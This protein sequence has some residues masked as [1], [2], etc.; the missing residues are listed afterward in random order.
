M[1]QIAAKNRQI[2]LTGRVPYIPAPFRKSALARHISG[3]SNRCIALKERIDRSTVSRILSQKEVVQKIARYQSRVLDIVPEAI[4]VVEAALSS[5][6]ERI[7]I[8]TFAPSVAPFR[9]FLS[10]SSAGNAIIFVENLKL[11][12]KTITARFSSQPSGQ[13]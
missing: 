8:F 12:D 5:P 6:D 10:R 11:F 4:R 7:A 13:L 2:Q 9:R 1:P 3:E